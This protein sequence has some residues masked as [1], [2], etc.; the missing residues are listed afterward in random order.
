[1][2][3]VTKGDGNKQ[4]IGSFGILSKRSRQTLLAILL[5][6]TVVLQLVVL[7]KICCCQDRAEELRIEFTKHEQRASDIQRFMETVVCRQ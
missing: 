4:Q 1:M 2:E 7:G 5:G 3:I 6:V